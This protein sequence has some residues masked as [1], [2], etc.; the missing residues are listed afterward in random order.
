MLRADNLTTL[1]CRLS[2]NPGAL[3]SR[4]PQGHVGLFRGY[5]LQSPTAVHIIQMEKI[6]GNKINYK[7]MYIFVHFTLNLDYI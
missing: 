6:M 4:K 1:V 7:N 3:T 2:R 5:F